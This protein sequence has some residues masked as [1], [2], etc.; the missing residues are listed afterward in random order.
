M[1]KSNIKMNSGKLEEF[2]RILVPEV[3]DEIVNIEGS[4]DE[5]N[6]I[7]KASNLRK[8]VEFSYEKIGRSFEEQLDVMAKIVLLKLYDKNYKWG[9]LIGVRPTKIVRRFL[10]S[11]FNLNYIENLLR[12]FYQVSKEKAELLIDVVK[13]ELKY[14]DKE[15]VGIYIGI[16]YCPTKCTYC[17]FPSYL[18]EGKHLERFDEYFNSL[19]HEIR[20]VGKL[21]KKLNLGVNTIYIGGGTPSILTKEEMD[22]MLETIAKN[23]DIDKLKEFTYELGRI[24]TIDEEKLEVLKKWKVDRISINPQTFNEKT[25][26]LVNRYYSKERFD[27]IF[28][29]AKE[30]GFIIN[31]DLILGLPGETTNDILYTLQKTREYDMQNLTIHNLAIKRSSQLNKENYSHVKNLNYKKIYS[32]IYSLTRSKELYPYYM[33]RQKNSFQSGEN[34]GYS[35]KDKESIYNIEMIEENKT[36]IGIGA[37]AMTKLVTGELGNEKIERIINPKDPLMWIDELYPRLE[38]K[39]KRITEAVDGD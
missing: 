24:D 19:I 21:V 35:V 3:E 26:I 18:K 11:G 13:R 9:S 1:V 29:K 14:L 8:T 34:I 2:I 27:E 25:S 39:K 33:Y 32:E 37:G 28:Q 22:K 4:E 20:E 31:M 12:E 16:A 36:V 15:T 10:D 5:R 7:V 38:N 6:F 17:S 30:M 23:Y